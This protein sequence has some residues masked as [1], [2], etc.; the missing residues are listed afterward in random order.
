[1][2]SLKKKKKAKSDKSN[3]EKTTTSPT[4]KRTPSAA[5][6]EKKA[7]DSLA[8]PSSSAR[9]LIKYRPGRSVAVLSEGGEAYDVHYQR[10]HRTKKVKLTRDDGKAVMLE[11]WLDGGDW[12]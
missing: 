7:P 9:E 3:Q 2:L 6:K 8:K 1:M 12:G 11:K 10:L 4:T 5:L